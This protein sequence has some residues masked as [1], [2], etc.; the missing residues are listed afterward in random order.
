MGTKTIAVDSEVYARLASAKREGESF[1]KTINRLLQ[2]AGAVH[3]G[4]E[5]LESLQHLPRLPQD[6]AEIMLRVVDENRTREAW[7]AHD[8][9]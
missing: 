4:K 7:P 6:E 1:S 2:D 5:I 9:R 3:T 8:L